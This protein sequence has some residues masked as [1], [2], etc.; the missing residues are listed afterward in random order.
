MEAENL[1]KD[2]LFQDIENHSLF[3]EEHSESITLPEEFLLL[4]KSKTCDNEVM[5]HKTKSIYGTQFHPEVSDNNGKIL[6]RNFLK[7]CS[8]K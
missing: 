1:A 5:K 7:L 2:D 4:A 6:F 3:Q 8:D